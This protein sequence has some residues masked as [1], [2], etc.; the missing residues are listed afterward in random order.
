MFILNNVSA[1][2][3]S[4][5]KPA[6]FDAAQGII[7]VA[8]LKDATDPDWKDGKDMKAWNAFMDK[9]APDVDRSDPSTVYAYTVARTM[10]QVLKQCSNDLTRANIMRQAANLKSLD[11]LML[12]PGISVNTSSTDFAP[13]RLLQLVRF[14]GIDLETVVSPPAPDLRPVRTSWLSSLPR[15]APEDF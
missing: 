1:S 3:G 5:L 8:Y 15:L 10:V 9:Y 11:P 2:V 13:I 6:G 14:E 7:S 12:L 4:V